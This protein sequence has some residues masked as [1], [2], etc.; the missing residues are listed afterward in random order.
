MFEFYVFETFVWR[1]CGH[2]AGGE[3]RSGSCAVPAGRRSGRTA[4][5]RHAPQPSAPGRASV[6]AK[7]Q[8]NREMRLFV[9][10]FFTAAATGLRTGAESAPGGSISP[11]RLTGRKG[12]AIFAAFMP[13]IPRLSNNLCYLCNRITRHSRRTH[14]QRV[15]NSIPA[16]KI[17][18]PFGVVQHG[19][20]VVG[21]C[22]VPLA[23]GEQGRQG[24]SAVSRRRS[25]QGLYQG[26]G[27]A[28]LFLCLSP[29]STRTTDRERLNHSATSHDASRA[30]T[31]PGHTIPDR[32]KPYGRYHRKP[33]DE[34]AGA[35]RSRRRA[36]VT[37]PDQ[38][39]CTPHFFAVRP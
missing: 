17:G 28:P 39:P 14:I 29:S 30:A 11:P 33:F 2:P 13:R 25:L 27:T 9:V 3:P 12:G 20:A 32:I 35:G 8:N 21:S 22:R 1:R 34:F 19:M 4:S 7:L 10:I 18:S 26:A 23:F 5:G 38:Q 15:R 31:C 16:S 37:S 36:S 6:A 24:R